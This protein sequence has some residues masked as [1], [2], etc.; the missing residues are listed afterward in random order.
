MREAINDRSPGKVLILR[1]L[2]WGADSRA[3]RW[4]NIYSPRPIRWGCWGVH[5]SEHQD[6]VI[7]RWRPSIGYTNFVIG[8][9][10]FIAMSFFY[11]LKHLRHGDILLCIDLET[12]LLGMFAAKLRGAMI[13]Y[14]MADPFFLAKPAPYKTF[15]KK[16]EAW[17][18]R[19]ADLATAPHESRFK[20]FFAKQPS[21]ARVV[22]NV[23]DICAVRC[24]FPLRSVRKGS[25]FLTLGYFGTLDHHR[26]LEDIMAFVE[27]H[28]D[29]QLKIGG[30]GVLHDLVTEVTCRCDRIQFVGTFKPDELVM[31]TQGV[32]VYCSLYY[33]SKPLHRFAA[34]NKYYEHLA[35]GLPILIS[36]NTP[37]ASDV[38]KNGTGW[39]IEDGR[40]ALE[41]W[42]ESVR[43]DVDSF[44]RCSE[45]ARKLWKALYAD[46]LSNQKKFF[47][48][49]LDRA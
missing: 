17:C 24:P 45:R 15:W 19:V 36:A 7:L 42:Y 49:F 8:Y 28:P 44:D 6:E 39:A 3:L 30:R 35:L 4:A 43:D 21:H 5:A 26:G 11:A 40:V 16:L 37:Y 31:L 29:V 34:P 41:R 47:A 12:A 1:A 25:F 20:L 32:D 10:A 38:L 22:E 46:W 23:P 27:D 9:V 18:I 48:D 14:D 13:H 33:C 2:P